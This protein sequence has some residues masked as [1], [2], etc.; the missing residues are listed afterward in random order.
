MMGGS[1]KAD[2]LDSTRIHRGWVPGEQQANNRQSCWLCWLL[3]LPGTAAQL[4]QIYNMLLMG[5]DVCW[6]KGRESTAGCV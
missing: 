1:C 3:F 6:A 4:R 2:K 5:F